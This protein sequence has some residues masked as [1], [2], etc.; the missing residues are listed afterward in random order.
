MKHLFGLLSSC[1]ALSLASFVPALAAGP[2]LALGRGASMPAPALPVSRIVVSAPASP[3][4]D[5]A[6]L[7]AP[8]ASESSA[9]SA[10]QA[11][12]TTEAA[13]QQ[14]RVQFDA[15]HAQRDL[16]DRLAADKTPKR[17]AG[18]IQ[19]GGK[20]VAVSVVYGTLPQDQKITVGEESLVIY[21]W[22]KNGFH[23]KRVVQSDGRVTIDHLVSIS[24]GKSMVRAIRS[25]RIMEKIRALRLDNRDEVRC[26]KSDNALVLIADGI[27]SSL[28]GN[29]AKLEPVSLPPEPPT[30]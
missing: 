25:G 27:R 18:T 11:P 14:G 24:S 26:S 10:L 12:P 7:I 1:A 13:A 2:R 19:L 21:H 30:R 17:L 9:E 4:T 20:T 22:D 6:R 28:I 3:R 8:L 5:G 15:A 23:S 29:C 16:L